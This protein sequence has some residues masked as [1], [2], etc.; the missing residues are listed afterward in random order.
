MVGLLW[1]VTAV[2]DKVPH[3]SKRANIA[4]FVRSSLAYGAVSS[5]NLLDI[6]SGKSNEEF[7][8]SI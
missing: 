1:E 5:T 8:Q 7:K 6:I 2:L 4:V 3:A